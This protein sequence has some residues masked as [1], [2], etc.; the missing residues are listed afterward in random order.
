MLTSETLVHVNTEI[1]YLF[2]LFYFFFICSFSF[3]YYYSEFDYQRLLAKFSIF[4]LY[5]I[6]YSAGLISCKH[7][8]SLK[9]AAPKKIQIHVHVYKSAGKYKFSVALFTHSHNQ[10]RNTRTCTCFRHSTCEFQVPSVRP[11]HIKYTTNHAGVRNLPYVGRYVPLRF[12]VGRYVPLRFYVG[13]YVPL[14]GESGA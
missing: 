11:I 13:R 1:F 8:V 9:N 4:L 12:Y 2:I 7:Q 14:R 10:S 6:K 5:G 3:L